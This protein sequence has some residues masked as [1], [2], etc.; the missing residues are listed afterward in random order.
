MSIDRKGEMELLLLRRIE[1]A[2]D[3][4][5]GMIKEYREKE[6]LSLNDIVNRVGCSGTY[7]FRAEK[8]SKRVPIRMRVQILKKGLGWKANEIKTFLVETVKRYE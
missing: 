7:L 8:G 2:I 1:N 3:N 4:F 6:L 5:G